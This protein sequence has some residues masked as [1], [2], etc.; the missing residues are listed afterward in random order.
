[1]RTNH[2]L[3]DGDMGSEGEEEGEAI[4]RRGNHLDYSNK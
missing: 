4:W 1:M 3:W 2:S